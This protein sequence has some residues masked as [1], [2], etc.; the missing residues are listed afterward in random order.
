MLLHLAKHPALN[1][2][3][4]VKAAAQPCSQKVWALIQQA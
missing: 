1:K 4:P 2:R 3:Q